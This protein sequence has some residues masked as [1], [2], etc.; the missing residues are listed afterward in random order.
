MAIGSMCLVLHGHLPYVLRHG[1][2]PHGED[3][4]YEAAAE[5]YLPI[6]DMIDECNFFNAPPRITIGLTP[7]LLEQLAHEHFKHGFEQ[8]LADRVDRARQDRKDFEAWNDGHLVYLATRWEEYYTKM[9]EQFAGMN[10]D[11]PSAFAERAQAG[12]IEILTSAATHAYL[13]LHVRRLERPGAAA[14]GLASSHRILGFKPRGMWLPEC[15][16]RRRRPVGPADRLG[17]QGKPHRPGAHD[18]RRDDH[19][20]LPGKPPHRKQPQRM[21]AQ[22]PMAPGRLG[23]SQP[24]IPPAAGETCTIPCLVNCDGMGPGRVA[25][26]GRDAKVCEQ[27]WSG[28]IGYPADGVYLEFHKRHGAKRGLRYWKITGNKVDLGGKHLYYPDNVPGKVHEHAT[29]F[30]NTVKSRLWD[31]HNQTGRHGVVMASFDAELFGHWWFEGPQFLRDVIM[32]LNADPD[33]DLPDRAAVPG[34]LPA[35][36]RPYRCRAGRWGEGGD[37]RVWA[38]DRV[39]WMWDIEYRCEANFG[40]MTFELP[41]KTDP[42]IASLL[43]KAARELLLLQASDWPFVITRGQAIDYGIKRFMLHVSRFETLHRPLREAQPGQR[44]PRP[45]ERG[46]AARGRGRRP[47]RRDIPEYRTGVVEDVDSGSSARRRPFGKN[48]LPGP[49]RRTWCLLLAKSRATICSGACPGGPS[50][51]TILEQSPTRAS[52]AGGYR[53]LPATCPLHRFIPDDLACPIPGS[54]ICTASQTMCRRRSAQ[55]K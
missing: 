24:S 13:P 55:Q 35:R 30:C 15:A 6:L 8:Y 27:V 31:Y 54:C 48:A 22:R 5:T 36:T 7:V 28:T 44:L 39:N 21:G 51:N 12:F 23:R 26:F 38:N 37:D 3:W 19:A 47:P 41:W 1:V 11:L 4:L 32:T 2:W 20:L 53:H 18:R 40:K 45:A 42:Q 33:V 25:A 16:Y 49:S 29:H 10:R 50:A 14:G 34:M 17:R 9:A 43:K 46:R 52:H